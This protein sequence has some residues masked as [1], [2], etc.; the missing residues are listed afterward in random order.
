MK[1]IVKLIIVAT[2]FA[3]ISSCKKEGNDQNAMDF[4]FIGVKDTTVVLGDTF[5]RELKIYYL[6]GD[7]EDVT[8]STI[9]VPNGVEISYSPNPSKPD[10]TL[11]QIIKVNSVADTGYFNL[12]VVAKG[13]GGK[14][15]QRSFQLH[16]PEPLKFRPKISLFGNQTVIITLNSPYFEVGYSAF[17]VEDGNLTSQ[18][19]VTNPL[20]INLQGQYNISYVVT[21]SDGNKD[22][23][24]RKVIMKNSLSEL[25]NIY[26]CSSTDLQSGVVHNWI[27]ALSSSDTLNNFCKIFKISDC[28]MANPV[29]FYDAV[30]DSIFLAP[31]TFLCI[32]ATDTLNHTFEGK[33]KFTFNGSNVHVVLFYTDK[34]VDPNS[35]NLITLN[36][37]DEYSI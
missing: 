6:G 25:S 14:I 27:G 35:G 23:V 5:S 26:N 9:G 13:T 11:S 21:D 20:N 4:K 24:V 18:V 30:K 15:F 17:D 33:G 31:Q 32:T 28:F 37:K 34:F 8:F 16:I 22:S 12:N 36:K 1:K 19:I 29:F 3:L 10:L 2:F 7:I